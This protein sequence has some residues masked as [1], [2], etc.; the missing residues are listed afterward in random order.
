MLTDDS[1][2]QMDIAY[3]IDKN[4]LI[5]ALVSIYSVIINKKN[6]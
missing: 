6:L 1:V 2:S 3:V 5:Y 4:V